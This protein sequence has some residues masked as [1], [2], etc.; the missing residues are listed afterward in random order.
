VMIITNIQSCEVSS[1]AQELD[2]ID[3]AMDQ[4]GMN[5]RKRSINSLIKGIGY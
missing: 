3:L 2:I 1:T 5:T 4:F